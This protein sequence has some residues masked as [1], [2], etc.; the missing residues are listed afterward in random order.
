MGLCIRNA[1]LDERRP[2]MV[3]FLVSVK[4]K[5]LGP[6][7]DARTVCVDEEFL[8]DL[9]FRS[10]GFEVLVSVRQQEFRFFTSR[11]TTAKYVVSY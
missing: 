1:V 8:V 11:R 5:R 6:S 10:K 3:L 2:E 7:S 4:K 9:C